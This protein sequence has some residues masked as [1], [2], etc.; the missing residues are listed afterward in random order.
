ML[1]RLGYVKGLSVSRFNRRLHKLRDW[2][3]EIV[4]LFHIGSN[5]S[6]L[7]ASDKLPILKPIPRSLLR[8]DSLT[9]ACRQ[10]SVFVIDSMPFPV[11]KRVR[12]RHCKKVRGKAFYGYCAAKK[13]KSFG[14]RLH[15]ICT[16][17][18]VP[19]NVDLLPASEQ[20]LNPIHELTFA[21]PEGQLFLLTKAIFLKK[22]LTVFCPRLAY[23]W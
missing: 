9:E 7:A 3:Y 22:M 20:D 15:L 12:A 10:G 2:L 23:V 16:A 17:S 6:R 11:C 21:L 8:G 19:V 1:M 14:W 4:C 18:G 5:T 13:E